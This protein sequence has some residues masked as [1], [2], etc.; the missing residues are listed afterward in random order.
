MVEH[1]NPT[2][3]TNLQDVDD[4]ERIETRSDDFVM[5]FAVVN[6]LTD[7]VIRENSPLFRLIGTT[8]SNSPDTDFEN[9][10]YPMHECTEEEF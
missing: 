7:E 1:K 5:A 6:Q 10:F 8:L 3:I 9:L 4:G 2:L